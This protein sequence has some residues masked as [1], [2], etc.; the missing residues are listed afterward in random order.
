VA[1][2]DRWSGARPA[3]RA[4]FRLVEDLLGVNAVAADVQGA[5]AGTLDGVLEYRDGRQ[6]AFEVMTYSG[7]GA[8]QLEAEL[9]RL[10]WALPA[11]GKLSWFLQPGSYQAFVR[12]RSTY[13]HLI[14]LC[15][16]EGVGSP[17]EL[18]L[19]VR[20]QDEDVRWFINDSLSNLRG[21]ELIPRPNGPTVNLVI[22]G[23]GGSSNHTLSGLSS[24][25]EGAFR[26][27]TFAKHLEKLGR[28][29]MNERHFFIP[30]HY[31]AFSFDVSD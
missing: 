7:V 23:R 12:L 8:R 25:L 18:P 31:L 14:E 6:A 2:D 17:Q 1:L 16:Q 4:A 24:E 10:G 29:P 13:A 26:E 11:P 21:H 27:K 15:E 9:A 3:E 20:R 28:S 5:P 19:T 30:V 22:P